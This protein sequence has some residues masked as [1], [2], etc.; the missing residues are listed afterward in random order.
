MIFGDDVEKLKT[1]STV[2]EN[3]KWCV[4]FEKWRSSPPENYEQ[5]CHVMQQHRPPTGKR[6]T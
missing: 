5:N 2:G 4:H 3:V 1:L 6:P